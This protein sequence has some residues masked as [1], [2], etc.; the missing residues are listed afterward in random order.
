VPDKGPVG[1][2]GVQ[3]AKAV[4]HGS[5]SAENTVANKFGIRLWEL[6]NAYR[7]DALPRSIIVSTRH[8]YSFPGEP[9]AISNVLELV[10]TPQNSPNPPGWD[11]RIDFD[12]CR[13]QPIQYFRS[14][15]RTSSPLE[16]FPDKGADR[17]G[18]TFPRSFRLRP[19]QL[20]LRLC[21]FLGRCAR[22]ARP[23]ILTKG[24]QSSPEA[25]EVLGSVPHL[26]LTNCYLRNKLFLHA[27]KSKFGPVSYS[28]LKHAVPFEGRRGTTTGRGTSNRCRH[29]WNPL[30]LS[31]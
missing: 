7:F 21:G 24:S 28:P 19:P 4:D 5:A 26:L 6:A 27:P 25:S 15:Q 31:L 18:S 30:A 2:S 1:G 17:S 11:L 16:L 10:G 3:L 12:T 9:V 13:I 22:S 23:T 8:W 29:A 14:I 20:L